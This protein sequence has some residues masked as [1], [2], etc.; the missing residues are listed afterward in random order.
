M[1]ILNN[2]KILDDELQI[3]MIKVIKSNNNKSDFLSVESLNIKGQIRK[4]AP[5]KMNLFLTA[6][7]N[8]DL[9]LIEINEK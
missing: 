9:K 2:I 3:K 8:D 7:N 4:F 1:H 5:L 6:I